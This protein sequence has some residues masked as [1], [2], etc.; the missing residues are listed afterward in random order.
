[1]PTRPASADLESTLTRKTFVEQ[2]RA[3]DKKSPVQQRHQHK[4][5]FLLD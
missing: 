1:V 2:R 3:P 4:F 5:H